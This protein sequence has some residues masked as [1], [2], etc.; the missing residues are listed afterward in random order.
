[1]G[2]GAGTR[3]VIHDVDARGPA[4][5][6]VAPG[7]ELLSLN[8]ARVGSVREFE[9]LTSGLEAGDLVSLIVHDGDGQR[10]V[11]YRAGP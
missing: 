11:N 8:G 1:P 7:W 2:T 4:Q 5:G 9:R 10:V 3:L 6:R